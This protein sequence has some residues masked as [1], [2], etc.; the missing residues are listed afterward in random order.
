MKVDAE[1]LKR[2]DAG[3]LA[4]ITAEV[5]MRDAIKAKIPKSK[6]RPQISLAWSSNLRDATGPN[7][8]RLPGHSRLQHGASSQRDGQ[9]RS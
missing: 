2:I 8:H 1:L 4:R 7:Q 9:P 5:A 3:I 6:N